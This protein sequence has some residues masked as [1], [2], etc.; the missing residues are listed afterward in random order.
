MNSQDVRTQ[1]VWLLIALFKMFLW[2]IIGI[3]FYQ[4]ISSKGGIVDYQHLCTELR[5][6]LEYWRSIEDENAQ[7]IIEM[8]KME[9]DPIYQKKLIRTHLGFIANDE[10]VVLSSKYKN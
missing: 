3:S 6:Q 10:Y 1:V 7:L 4:L 9:N 5:N 8:N 2:C